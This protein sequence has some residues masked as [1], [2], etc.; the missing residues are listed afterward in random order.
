MFFL[1]K[2][3]TKF[4]LLIEIQSSLIRGILVLYSRDSS[5]PPR[6]VFS[7][8]YNI[9][10]K[11]HVSNAYYIES[12]IRTLIQIVDSAQKSLHTL[13]G[14]I[15]ELHFILSSPWIVS[16]AR[17]VSILFDKQTTI[18]TD[19]VTRILDDERKNMKVSSKNGIETVDEKIFDVRLN[20]YSI[21]A[22][23]GKGATSLEVSYAISIGDS[24]TLN[25]LKNV[26]GHASRCKRIFFHSALILEYIYLRDMNSPIK[27]YTLINIHDELTDILIV[28]R[29]LCSFFGSFP[30][31]IRKILRGIA[32]RARIDLKSAESL[33]SLYIGNYIDINHDKKTI[34]IISE[35]STTWVSALNKLFED[36]RI[37]SSIPENIYL[38]AKNHEEFF[39]NAF[40]SIKPGINVLKIDNSIT[41][42]YIHAIHSIKK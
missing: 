8:E 12:V 35:S 30:I 20:G 38:I 31:G 1:E 9:S 15:G 18:N 22:W 13:S 26:I 6:I 34:S 33:L 42:V 16:Q 21:N 19:R 14:Y 10:F 28:S 11:S 29:N 32:D 37:L 3:N 24:S 4:D 40:R 23:Q 17:T 27:S 36:N 7:E 25:K 39:I 5:L 41:N 2:S